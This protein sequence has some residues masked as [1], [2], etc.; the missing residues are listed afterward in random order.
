MA[1]QL[2]TNVRDELIIANLPSL[3]SSAAPGPVVFPDFL[4]GPEIATQ[5]FVLG[6]GPDPR[7][8]TIEFFDPAGEPLVVI[9]R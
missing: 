8:G 9:L 6:T 5:L 2:T 7:R 3:V 4:D 1:H